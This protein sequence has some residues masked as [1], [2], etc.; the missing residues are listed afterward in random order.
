[1]LN[2]RRLRRGVEAS[3]YAVLIVILIGTI[4]GAAAGWLTGNVVA[5]V[6]AVVPI[7]FTLLATTQDRSEPMT[8]ARRAADLTVHLAPQQ[9][10]E[11]QDQLTERGLEPDRRITVQ[12]RIAAGSTLPLDAAKA[13]PV[14]GTIEQLCAI[15]AGEAEQGRSPR[16]VI[17]GD[18][19]AGKTATALLLMAE[20]TGRDAGLPVLFQLAGWHPDTP[21][22]PW[23]A[24]QLVQTLPTIGGST[25]GATQYAAEV[26]AALMRRHVLPVL[27]GLDEMSEPGAALRQIDEEMGGRPFVLTRRAGTFAEA[28]RGYLLH[29]ALIVELLPLEREEIAAVL[30]GYA[31]P[32][33]PLSGLARNVLDQPAGPIATALSTPFMMSLAR[34]SPMPVADLMQAAT[35]PQAVD[36]IR[37]ELLGAFVSRAY[38]RER[39]ASA[40]RNLRFLARHADAAGRIAWWELH[41][42]VPRMQFVINAI[43]IAGVI[44][45]GMVAG[46]FALF[47]RAT[48]GVWIGLIAGVVGA[49]VVEM[50]PQDEPRRARPR[51]WLVRA[52]TRRDLARVLGF[53]ATGAAALAVIGY[54][55]YDSAGDVIA[56]SLISGMTFAGARYLGQSNDPL[57][58]VTPR[59]MLRADRRAVL[60]TGL[61]G[62]AAGALTGGYL[63]LA[64]R[65]GHLREYRALTILRHQPWQLGL[66]GAASGCVLTSVGIGLMAMGSSSWARFIWTR[67]WLAASG[68]VPLR[69]MHFLDDAHK[70][71]ILRQVSGYYE[72]RHLALQRYLTEPKLTGPATG[73]ELRPTQHGTVPAP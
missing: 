61:T 36:R 10:A 7:L 3:L 39:R 49:C 71:D 73:P 19:G 31:P 12:W 14:T 58:R 24:A 9:R 32:G 15:V 46:F 48:L 42:A 64:F 41:R 44:C 26:A 21:L 4:A 37:Q 25:S 51:L 35:G 20:L 70:R 69:L 17:T 27:D 72:F 29:R 40:V 16:L 53:G 57:L 60:V 54:F 38:P 34:E 47:H 30:T 52:P 55:L 62:A 56:G 13:V 23:L 65:V 11:L 59:S 6:A 2:I 50:V 63:G 33:G 22:R 1:M 8:P 66:L 67:V 45:S 68:K 18:M 5:A 28:N 43:L